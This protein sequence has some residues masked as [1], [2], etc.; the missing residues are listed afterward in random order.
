MTNALIICIFVHMRNTCCLT[1]ASLTSFF[2]AL[3]EPN[4]L[5]IL[6]WLSKHSEP[7]SVKA[8]ASCCEVDLSVVS[9]HLSLMRD[10]G[11]LESERRG[12]EVC[13]SIK[14]Q[15]V[16]ETLRSIARDLGSMETHP[17]SLQNAEKRESKTLKKQK[18][19]RRKN[20][21]C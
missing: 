5:C 3:C 12:K 15:I 10:A 18:S 7:Q 8:V 17:T 6:A 14:R 1:G 21:E 13:Y 9:R 2:K 19:E 11:I 4:R 16:S 20:H